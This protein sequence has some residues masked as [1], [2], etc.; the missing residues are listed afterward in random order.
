MGQIYDS[1]WI[2]SIH[3]ILMVD[4]QV[5]AAEKRIGE[6]P[7]HVPQ[8]TRTKVQR[9]REYNKGGMVMDLMVMPV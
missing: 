9:T 4:G 3:L 2:T 6:Y 1:S 5:P 8:R 7:D